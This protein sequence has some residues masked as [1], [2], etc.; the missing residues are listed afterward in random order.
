MRAAFDRKVV[1]TLMNSFSTSEDTRAF[2][3]KQHA[4]LLQVWRS[5]MECATLEGDHA[6]VTTQAVFLPRAPDPPPPSYSGARH[7]A[8]AEQ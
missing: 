2:L 6:L 8:D 3:A 1:F 7:R 4:D 5:R